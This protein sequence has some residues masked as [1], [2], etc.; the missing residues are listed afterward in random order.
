M[1][2][3]SSSLLLRLRQPGDQAGWQRFVDLYTPLLYYWACRMGLPAP[4]AADLVQDVFVT[5]VQKLPQFEYDSRKSFRS[6]LRTITENRWRDRQRR[7]AT[8][9]HSAGAAPLADVAVS[10]DAA[11]LWEGEYRQF[12]LARAAQ[13]MQAEFQPATWKACWALVVEGKTG[14]EVA[15]ELGMTLDAVYAARSRVLRRLRRELEGL[16]D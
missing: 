5:L 4:D 15:A 14:A 11:A 1:E 7:R 10:D 12:L 3:T 8:V 9:P 13:V 6:W 2:S 16:L